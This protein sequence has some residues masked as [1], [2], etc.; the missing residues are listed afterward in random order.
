MAKLE[1]LAY[2]KLKSDLLQITLQEQQL[3]NQ[4]ATLLAAHGLSLVTHR[5][6]DEGYEVLELT[7]E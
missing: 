5:F 1:P 3:L 6:N 7:E 2:F 4:K